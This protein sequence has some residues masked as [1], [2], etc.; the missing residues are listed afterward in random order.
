MTRQFWP[1]V[2]YGI[3]CCTASLGQLEEALRRQYYQLLPI[4]G[5]IR[6]APIKLRMLDGGF[7]GIGLPHPGIECL[8]AQLNKLLMHFG[9]KSSL[10]VL[11]QTSMELFILELGF[12]ATDPFATSFRRYGNL[13]TDGWI[14]SIWEKCD[15]FKI[16]IKIGNVTL[17][18]PREGDR[19]IMPVLAEAGHSPEQLVR[20]NRVR[21]H[22][23]ILFLSD[24]TTASGRVVDVTRTR[25]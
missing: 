14:K 17:E 21:I 6:S 15:H 7:G 20:L 13:V 12:S 23:Q 24:I 5:F 10:G 4:R 22:Q 18:P 11:L 2:G 8:V 19:W 1:L 9:C 16:D 25:R 3:S